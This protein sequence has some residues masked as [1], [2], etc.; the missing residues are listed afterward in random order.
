MKVLIL[1]IGKASDENRMY[2]PFENIKNFEKSKGKGENSV[3][4]VKYKDGSKEFY[5]DVA[6]FSVEVF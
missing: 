4:V 6:K 3:I 2:I 1:F 5:D